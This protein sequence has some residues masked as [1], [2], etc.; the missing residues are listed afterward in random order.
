[1]GRVL[2]WVAVGLAV[3]ALV[4]V[5]A[6]YFMDEPVRAFIERQLNA[7][8]EGYRFTIGK[9]HLSPNMTLEIRDG[10]MIQLAHPDPPVAQVPLW[11]FSIQWRHIFSGMLV[12][13]TL[14]ERPTLYVTLTQAKKEVNDKVPI[15][16]K[17][18]REAIYSF[19]PVKINEF[20][21]VNADVTYVDQDP[22]KPLKLHH[23]TFRA[24]N[25]RNL[26]YKDS[27]YPSDIYVDAVV[28]DSGKIWLKGHANFLAKPH[29][30]F[31]VDLKLD[32]VA[33]DY[34][35]PVTARYNLQLR[36]G[37][38]WA[39]GRMEYA[40][41]DTKV[42]HLKR[43]VIENL[44]AD[45]VH[46][47]QTQASEA[48]VATKAVEAGKALQNKPD[49]L[50]RIDHATIRNSDF[51]F[52]NEMSDPRYRVFLTNGE[53]EM[54]N[55]S[56][57]FTEGIGVMK[58]KGKFMGS[59][60]TVL[61]AS[62]RPEAKS[63]DFDLSVKIEETQMRSMNDLLRAYGKFDVVRGLFSFYSELSVKNGHIEGYVKPLFKDMKAYDKRQDAEKSL[64]RKMYEGLIDG[65]ATLLKN[66]QRQE[67]ATKATISGPV[68]NT[69]TSTWEMVVRLIQNAF[70]DAILPGFDRELF[71]RR[72][73]AAA[74]PPP[75]NLTEARPRSCEP[76]CTPAPPS[77]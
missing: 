15:H 38:L 68:G 57:Q 32:D 12:S 50:I 16:E 33:L 58:L 69:K 55:V 24:G 77:P 8:V 76:N 37:V 6:F 10:T 7:H 34:F 3:L 41:D 74:V 67:V 26:H 59:G 39:E 19:Y 2:R 40:A 75:L 47:P 70:F 9:A 31:N 73:T 21:V 43:L 54:E 45:Y 23:L 49:T 29:F 72:H 36:K 52:V 64:F 60:D 62:F 56:N 65:M 11:R 53:L 17:G 27:A 20:K 14:I 63:P 44:R 28:F 48:Q 1:M 22:K 61:K 46:A 4:I 25:I 71:G 42:A 66:R 51:G 18:W 5:V 30:G 35:L 13:D